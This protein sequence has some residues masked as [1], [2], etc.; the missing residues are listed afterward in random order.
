M[1]SLKIIPLF[2][3]AIFFSLAIS[4]CGGK[5][6]HQEKKDGVE[7]NKEGPEY[8]SAYVCPMHC[9]GSGSDG[10]G[11]CPVCGMDYV[12]NKDKGH[13]HDGHDHDGHD[14]DGHNH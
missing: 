8:T 5:H 14:H 7:I 1:K 6:T 13:D 4:S 9:E 10:P 11:K 3:V 12:E 2:V